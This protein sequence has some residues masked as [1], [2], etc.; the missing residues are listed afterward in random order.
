MLVNPK[1]TAFFESRRTDRCVLPSSIPLSV[2]PKFSVAGLLRVTPPIQLS[3]HV[4][5]KPDLT[6]G[7]LPATPVSRSANEFRARHASSCTNVTT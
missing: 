2:L 7:L 1:H 5:N 3:L 6:T 4:C